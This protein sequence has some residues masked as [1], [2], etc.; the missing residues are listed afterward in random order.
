M[1]ND[2]KPSYKQAAIN[3]QRCLIPLTGFFEHHW[4]D[5]S[6][7][8]KIP[9]YVTFKQ[10]SIMSATGLYSRWKDPTTGE[11]YYS[12]TVITTEANPLMK[13]VHNNG[14]RM[15]VFIPKEFEKDWLN[16]NLSKDDVLAMCQPFPAEKMKANTISKLL[17]KKEVETNVE[18]VLRPHRYENVGTDEVFSEV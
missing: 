9:Y 15:P 1:Y 7:K 8:N 17:T 3:G 16:R 6:G 4:A 13:Y 12:Y 14:Q 5:K 2:D 10:G 11:Y 18:D